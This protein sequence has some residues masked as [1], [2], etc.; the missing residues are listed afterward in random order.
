MRLTGLITCTNISLTF[1]LAEPF[2]FRKITTDLHIL[3]HVDTE[4]LDDRYA[5]L[6]MYISEKILDRSKYIPVVCIAMHCMV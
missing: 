1:F 4:F 6:K 3:A 2:W 5:K